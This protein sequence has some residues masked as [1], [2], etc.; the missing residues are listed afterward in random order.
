MPRAD[1]D[2]RDGLTNREEYR[3]GTDPTNQGQT[4]FQ[5]E[6]L[7]FREDPATM[8]DARGKKVTGW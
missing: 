7:V 2:S 6:D 1:P 5:P 3:A 8:L 4:L